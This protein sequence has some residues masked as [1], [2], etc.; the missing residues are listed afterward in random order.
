[1]VEPYLTMAEIE[2]KYPNEWVLVDKLKKGRDGFAV[3]GIV[4]AHGAER[5]AVYQIAESLPVPRDVAIF[6]TGP[7][8]EDV[9]FVL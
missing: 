5:G 8:P 9:L 4:A 6:Y 7:I 2:A 1:M 3:G